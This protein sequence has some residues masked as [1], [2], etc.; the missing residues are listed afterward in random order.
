[1][2]RRRRRI[3]RIVR[4]D[5]LVLALLAARHGQLE[6]RRCSVTNAQQV[7]E[8]LDLIAQVTLAAGHVPELARAVMKANGG[9]GKVILEILVKPAEDRSSADLVITATVKATAPSVPT[10]H[11]PAHK[12]Y[13]LEDGE[14][15]VQKPLPGFEKRRRGERERALPGFDG[16]ELEAEGRRTVVFRA[17][18]AEALADG[19]AELEGA[20]L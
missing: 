7:I 10:V 14:L 2:V 8:D 3:D 9:Q 15:V 16:V 5:A 11:F 19:A 13:R 12:S 20:A 6:A 17:E 1:V 18:D 4:V